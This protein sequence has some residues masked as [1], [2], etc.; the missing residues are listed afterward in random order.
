MCQQWFVRQLQSAQL[1]LVSAGV[2]VN[3]HLGRD[4]DLPC[5]T[6][7]ILVNMSIMLGFWRKS[8]I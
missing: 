5:F 2:D 1:K 3:C 8:V 7:N 6:S 4:L